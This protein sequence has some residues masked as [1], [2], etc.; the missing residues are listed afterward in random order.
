MAPEIELEPLDGV[1]I[2]N[3]PEFDLGGGRASYG[4]SSVPGSVYGHP[5]RGAGQQ[6]D[7]EELVNF[8]RRRMQT[9]GVS[10]AVCTVPDG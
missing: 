10:S 1:T 4:R 6:F 2:L 5:Q 3:Q 7:L 9:L 8:S